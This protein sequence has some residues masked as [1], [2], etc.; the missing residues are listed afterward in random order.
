MNAFDVER[1]KTFFDE[2]PELGCERRL[3]DFIL[4][5]K[6]VDRIGRA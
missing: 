5:L 6:Q 3:L 2:L 4:A 1:T